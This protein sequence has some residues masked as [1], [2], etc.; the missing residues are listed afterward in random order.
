MTTAQPQAASATLA[1]GLITTMTELLDIIE[2]ET[3]LVRAGKVVEAMALQ[4]EK[5]TLSQHYMQA[6]ERLK[7]AEAALASSAPDLLAALR[8]HHETFRALLAANLTVL[9]TAHAVS[10]GIV[11]GVNGEMQRKHT[12]QTYT[13]S[14]QH[15]GA[16][17]RQMSPLAVSRTL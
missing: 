13:A 4:D 17:T 5:A 16:A 15:A 2:R 12:P 11:R 3:T 8:R 1:E 14:G 9:A 7:G 10:E 6:V